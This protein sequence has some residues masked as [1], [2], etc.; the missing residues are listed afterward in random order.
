[1]SS[2]VNVITRIEHHLL[3]SCPCDDCKSERRRRTGT[4]S[5]H[6]KLKPKEAYQLGIINKLTPEGS[7]VR[8][9]MKSGKG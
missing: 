8:Q 3:S 9:I 6:I 7:K 1:M 4:S 2:D 5:Q